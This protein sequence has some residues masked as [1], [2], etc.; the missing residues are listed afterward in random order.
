MVEVLCELGHLLGLDHVPDSAELMNGHNLGLLD[1][2][3][4]DRAGQDRQWSLRV[5]ANRG[6]GRSSD[7]CRESLASSRT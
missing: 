4:G 7:L 6:T 3:P 2:G 5:S 1:Y